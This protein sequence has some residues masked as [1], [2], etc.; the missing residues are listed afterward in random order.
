MYSIISIDV[1]A[2]DGRIMTW[3]APAIIH[4]RLSHGCRKNGIRTLATSRIHFHPS[5]RAQYY[6]LTTLR[7][8][9][10]VSAVSFLSVAVILDCLWL[11]LLAPWVATANRTIC[12]NLIS[13]LVYVQLQ[14]SL[15]QIL[16]LDPFSLVWMS[17][18][19]ALCELLQNTIKWKR[20]HNY[21]Y[22]PTLY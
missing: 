9:W 19:Y 22:Q 1:T 12:C 8:L 6:F 16:R 11:S 7:C 3:V 4:N 15:N 20:S 21:N 14:F 5:F 10:P 17:W 18:Q 2:K 13:F